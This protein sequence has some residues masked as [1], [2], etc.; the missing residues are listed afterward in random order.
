MYIMR[1]QYKLFYLIL[2]CP[3]VERTLLINLLN[4]NVFPSENGSHVSHK[5]ICD[6][7][8]YRIS[9]LFTGF[10]Q[11]TEVFEYRFSRRIWHFAL[12]EF[13]FTYLQYT[14]GQSEL[15]F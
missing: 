4:K 1:T 2:L 12:R 6:M 9:R 14:I 11:T 5:T 13:V 15:V 3:I 7:H 8:L 10:M